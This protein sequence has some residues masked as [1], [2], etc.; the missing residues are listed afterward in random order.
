MPLVT[1]QE[2]AATCRE[3]LALLNVLVNSL[4]VSRFLANK[5]SA[6]CDEFLIVARQEW[7]LLLAMVEFVDL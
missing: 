3:L 4:W 6:W 7:L 1:F 2:L 5:T